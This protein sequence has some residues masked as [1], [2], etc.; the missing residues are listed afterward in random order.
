MKKMVCNILVNINFFFFL[1]I[2]DDYSGSESF[3]C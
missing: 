1:H 3:Q 2:L